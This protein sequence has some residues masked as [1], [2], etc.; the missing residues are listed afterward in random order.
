[1]YKT[2]PERAGN[3]RRENQLEKNLNNNLMWVLLF[4][5]TKWETEAE[6]D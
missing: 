6:P 3:W 5:F 1:M 4:Y 2:K